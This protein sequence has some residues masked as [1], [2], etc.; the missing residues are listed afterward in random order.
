MDHQQKEKHIRKHLRKKKMNHRLRHHQP[1]EKEAKLLLLS[2]F[3]EIL[4]IKWI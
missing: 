3:N 4:L 1:K 2:L